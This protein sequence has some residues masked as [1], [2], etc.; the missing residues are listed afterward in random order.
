MPKIFLMSIR[1]AI[2]GALLQILGAPLALAGSA[3]Q[4]H[5]FF[6]RSIMLDEM[7][8]YFSAN[9]EDKA[10][11]IDRF[12]NT[13]D[14]KSIQKAVT[15]KNDLESLL[16]QI[17]REEISGI[18]SKI[19]KSGFFTSA[20]HE[21][22]VRSSV[23][24]HKTL[25]R[26]ELLRIAEALES[27]RSVDQQLKFSKSK[28]L[29]T[30]LKYL[31][32]ADIEYSQMS[33]D[34]KYKLAESLSVLYRRSASIPV[35]KRILILDNIYEVLKARGGAEVLEL[36][37]RHSL[38]DMV[39]V[40]AGRTLG[41]FHAGT[42]NA[43]FGASAVSVLAAFA[44]PLG[45]V[46]DPLLASTLTIVTMA[47]G[48]AGL[49]A[50]N[51]LR[52]HTW[53]FEKA[54]EKVVALPQESSV[55]WRRLKQKRNVPSEVFK[56]IE[57]QRDQAY[58]SVVEES[59]MGAMKRELSV[60]LSKPANLT[61]WG[62]GLAQG[63]EG[64][65]KTYKEISLK[66]DQLYKE[67]EGNLKIVDEFNVDEGVK[68]SRLNQNKEIKSQLSDLVYE[69]ELLSSELMTLG[70]VLDL[71]VDKAKTEF[72]KDRLPKNFKRFLAAQIERLEVDKKILRSTALT[73]A[74]RT[75]LLLELV[76]TD[77]MEHQI[78]LIDSIEP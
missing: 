32:K 20:L 64:V 23:T 42:K 36:T 26:D 15:L 51:Y 65:L 57:A 35:R 37:M 38:A 14:P 10:I 31:F 73:T 40:A 22:L 54:A 63:I 11:A 48:T 77:S 45:Y 28:K 6:G 27:E 49:G 24:D 12:E 39:R 68:A 34:Q 9:H 52:K 17:P 75:Q 1:S 25:T 50:V 70:Y 78:R 44:T 61:L 4:C 30:N 60:D 41:K 47:G 58:S 74:N 13:P 69:W 56:D 16:V 62:S 59:P 33:L 53:F 66:Y 7:A 76:T 3:T 72:E 5:T 46:P 43:L 67:F 2:F 55:F 8:T 29:I 19:M 71:Y 18:V 21:E